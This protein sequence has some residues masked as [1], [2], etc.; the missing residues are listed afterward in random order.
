MTDNN[1][2]VVDQTTY[3]FDKTSENFNDEKNNYVIPH[4]ITVTITLNEYRELLMSKAKSIEDK[5]M[6]DGWEKDS[7]IRELKEEN[8]KLKTVID[9]LKCESCIDTK[10]DEKVVIE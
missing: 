5:A 2:S 6:R 3:H 7:K 9:A 1:K 4:E 8:E 10:D